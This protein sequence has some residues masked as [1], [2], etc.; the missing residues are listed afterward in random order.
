MLVKIMKVIRGEFFSVILFMMPILF[1]FVTLFFKILS[2]S[3]A[4]QRQTSSQ[5]DKTAVNCLS[6][7]FSFQRFSSSSHTQVPVTESASASGE[8][9]D[10]HG[11]NRELTSVEVGHYGDDATSRNDGGRDGFV[12]AAEMLRSLK[13]FIVGNYLFVVNNCSFQF[14]LFKFCVVLVNF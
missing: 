1:E 6:T 8:E 9:Y 5:N 2:Q 12:S 11:N 10:A 7:M 4:Q 3:M 14:E 13:I